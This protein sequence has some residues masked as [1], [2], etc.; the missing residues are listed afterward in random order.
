M[1]YFKDKNGKLRKIN[2]I[3]EHLIEDNWT[4]LTKEQFENEISKLNTLTG[5]DLIYSQISNLEKLVTNRRLRECSLGNTES[6]EFIQD[7]D[8]QIVELRSQLV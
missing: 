7:I 8:N 2:F 6:I 1:K 3:Q 4:E 5:N